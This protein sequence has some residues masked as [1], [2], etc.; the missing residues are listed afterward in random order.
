MRLIVAGIAVCVLASQASAYSVTYSDTVSFSSSKQPPALATVA[1][2]D[3]SLG[4]LQTVTVKFY[5][6]GSVLAQ[7]DN[8]DPYNTGEA[9]GSMV[10]T[11]DATGPGVVASASKTMT[12]PNVT[13]APDNG[14][15]P[16]IDPLG[17]DG[18]DYS[19]ALA[20]GPET[21]GPY[22]PPVALYETL[23]PGSVSFT[24]TP[25]VMQNVLEWLVGSTPP[26]VW[27]RQVQDPDL[28]V[29]AEVTYHYIPEPATLGLLSLG[30]VFLRKRMG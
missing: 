8:D 15:G 2:F 4:T 21:N 25:T 1:S 22:T 14:D 30:L 19:S 13:L 12:G 6:S 17:P 26:D 28:T 18:I 24:I 3:T 23:G 16:V 5:H 7:V 11:W 20:Y 29:K 27:Q 10:R 9:A